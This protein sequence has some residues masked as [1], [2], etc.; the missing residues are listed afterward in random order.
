MKNLMTLPGAERLTYDRQGVAGWPQ[1]EIYA[2]HLTTLAYR[3]AYQ[4]LGI[5]YSRCLAL[6]DVSGAF[7]GLLSWCDMEHVRTRHADFCQV[8]PA[9]PLL[10][11]VK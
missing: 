10:K 9:Q 7:F 11:A 6:L 3:T 5:V 2:H 8:Q 4:Y 1:T